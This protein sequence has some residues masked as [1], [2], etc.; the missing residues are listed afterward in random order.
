MPG[1]RKKIK[2][3]SAL[4]EIT[5]ALL[6][7]RPRSVTYADLE[8]LSGVPEAWIKAF[9]QRRM[10]NPSVVRVEALYNVLSDEPLELPYEL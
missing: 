3:A 7:N 5:L 8:K 2:T 4:L 9:G 1:K 6:D 10:E